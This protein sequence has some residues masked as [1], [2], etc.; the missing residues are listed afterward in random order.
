M[1][2]K[3]RIYADKNS[4]FIMLINDL[5]FCKGNIGINIL[6]YKRK[7]HLEEKKYKGAR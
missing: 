5:R 1:K 6:F 4:I 7:L 2:E 3:S